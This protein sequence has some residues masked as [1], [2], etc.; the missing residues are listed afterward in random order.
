MIAHDIYGQ[1][2]GW[3]QAGAWNVGQASTVP[4]VTGV[5]PSNGSG[6]AG[7]PQQFTV[8]YSGTNITYGQIL[9]NSNPAGPY[10]NGACQVEW[11]SAGMLNLLSPGGNVDGSFGQ[12]PS[13][14]TNTYCTVDTSNSTLVR[15]A[16]GY[17]VSIRA[18]QLS[19]S[20]PLEQIYALGQNSQGASPLLNVGS[21]QPIRPTFHASTATKGSSTSGNG[22]SAWVYNDGNDGDWI[23]SGNGDPTS[24]ASC[25]VTG[26]SASAKVANSDYDPYTDFGNI[27]IWFT[28]P[29]TSSPGTGSIQC[30]GIGFGSLVVYESTP[31]ITAL[32]LT[33]PL[34]AGDKLTRSS[35]VPISART[36]A[37]Q[38]R[39]VHR[40]RVRARRRQALPLKSNTGTA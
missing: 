35:M 11:N 16:S 4:T 27:S 30:A 18:T 17:D 39:S 25:S 32:Q 2:S 6:T 33:S 34:S 9:L 31:V 28:A 1:F 14:L 37:E 29:S 10:S 40:V 36:L 22:L 23:Y 7:T 15:T 3:T 19:T 20:T 26:V 8:H 5:T 38:P 21:W 24:I 12:F 13:P